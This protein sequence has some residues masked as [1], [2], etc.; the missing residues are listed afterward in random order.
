MKE[1][2]GL[3]W[4][5]GRFGFILSVIE[6]EGRSYAEEWQHLMPPLLS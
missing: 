5:G 4:E 1:F 6:E 2:V 3:A